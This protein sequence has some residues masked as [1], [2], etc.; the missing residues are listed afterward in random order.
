VDSASLA[1][2][3]KTEMTV[4]LPRWA[5]VAAGVVAF[6]LLLVALD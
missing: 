4:R 5:F 6:A 2:W 3:L 1:V